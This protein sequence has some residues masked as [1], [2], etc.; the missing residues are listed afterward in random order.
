MADNNSPEDVTGQGAGKAGIALQQQ[1]RRQGARFSKRAKVL[2]IGSVAA[3]LSLIFF[4][5]MTAGQRNS[6]QGAAFDDRPGSIRADIKSM[7]DLTPPALPPQA[8]AARHPCEDRNDSPWP[9]APKPKVAASQPD[10]AQKYEQWLIDQHFKALQDGV[11]AERAALGADVKSGNVQIAQGGGTSKPQAA[12]PQSGPFGRPVREGAGAASDLQL[13][14][15]QSIGQG[16]NGAGIDSNK[17]WQ[18]S[19]GNHRG[20]GGY[21]AATREAARGD[22]ELFAGSVIPATMVTAINSDLPGTI[23][24]TVRR[25]V[26]D[27]RD[28][29]T[30][31]IPQNAQLIG[32]YNSI[33]QYGQQRLMVVWNQ[34]TYPDGST[35]DLKGMAGVNAQGEAGFYDQVDNHYLRVF[36]SAALISLF[37][38]AA[39]MSQP[40]NSSMFTTPD[41]SQQA[42]A[43]FATQ[44]NTAA[45]NIL[46][47]NLQIAP[48]L[49]IRP[50]YMFNAMVN[51]TVIL[52]P[53]LKGD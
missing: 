13:A 21:L 25:T 49:N 24:A 16:H 46:N 50:G 10:A 39:Q 44:M 11:V 34:L 47:K 38:A 7:Q 51:K 52:E 2:V 53:W 26:Y 27:S 12:A 29:S 42:T 22:Y 18:Q 19:V 28:P 40:Q 43:Q 4:G 48:T 1:P 35:L 36:G 30:V 3:L 31:L 6:Q 8:P 23:T 20:A 5:I 17:A 32:E 14:Y 15:L 45:A 33:V 37:G 41:M 9:C